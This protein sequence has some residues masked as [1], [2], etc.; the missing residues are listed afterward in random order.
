MAAADVDEV[1]LIV[2]LTARAVAPGIRIVSRVNEAERLDRI[3]RVGA[4]VAQS[5]YTHTGWRWRPRL[6]QPR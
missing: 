1:S 6:F 2:V 3:A 4:G 5:P